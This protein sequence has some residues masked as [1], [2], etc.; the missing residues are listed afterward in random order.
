M[1]SATLDRVLTRQGW[2]AG[3]WGGQASLG[4]G[5]A[6]FDLMA[7]LLSHP[8]TDVAHVWTTRWK[9]SAPSPYSTPYNTDALTARPLRSPAGSLSGLCR[10]GRVLPQAD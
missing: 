4:M 5:L 10:P 9:T 8:L 3:K 1:H 7:Q 2:R 6:T